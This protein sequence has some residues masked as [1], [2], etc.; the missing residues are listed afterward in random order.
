MNIVPI[1]G[2]NLRH[3]LKMGLGPKG[4]IFY[5]Q[6]RQASSHKLQVKADFQ[7]AALSCG[8]KLLACGCFA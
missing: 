7:T 6:K 1:V 3:T 8:L 2:A 4:R 5:E